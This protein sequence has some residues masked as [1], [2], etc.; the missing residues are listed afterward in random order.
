[1]I[2]HPLGI[3][4]KKQDTAS[5]LER[6]TKDVQKDQFLKI[7]QQSMVFQ[8]NFANAQARTGPFLKPPPAHSFHPY[9]GWAIACT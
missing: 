6:E 8:H 1:M 5:Q 2:G 9:A 4:V 7:T 3:V